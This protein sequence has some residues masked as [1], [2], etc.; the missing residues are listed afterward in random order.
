M[1]TIASSQKEWGG[2]IMH[3]ITHAASSTAMSLSSPSL[4]TRT[5]AS[6]PPLSRTSAL[7]AGQSLHTAAMAAAASRVTAL[8]HTAP[9]GQCSRTEAA[10]PRSWMNSGTAPRSRMS[11][12]MDA[13][14][15]MRLTSVAVA[16]AVTCIWVGMSAPGLSVMQPPP[17][18]PSHLHGCFCMCPVF[19]C[20]A[21]GRA[22]PLEAKLSQPDLTMPS[23][24]GMPPS[25]C[26]ALLLVGW[27]CVRA[28][29]EAQASR[30]ASPMPPSW[31]SFSKAAVPPASPTSV[32]AA[33]C[34]FTICPR[35][36]SAGTTTGLWQPLRSMSTNTK[37]PPASRTISWLLM[38]PPTAAARARL[39]PLES[40]WWGPAMRCCMSSR[41]PPS[42]P[43]S[44]WFAGCL[45]QRAARL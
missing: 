5:S 25:R 39:A 12:L 35:A 3:L 7:V 20:H 29:S 1:D 24:T 21:P 6:M 8:S 14:P 11:A 2:E 27:S 18:S 30:V 34:P 43:I 45:Q 44:A 4:S 38:L 40:S 23:S 41:R 16:L 26:T 28:A 31:I 15:V 9:C 33:R 32:C 13:L 42:S 22:G 37:V 10:R 17:A 36:C 19:S